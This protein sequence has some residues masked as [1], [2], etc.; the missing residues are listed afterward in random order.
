MCVCVCMCVHYMCVNIINNI[1]IDIFYIS[2]FELSQNKIYMFNR[3][4]CTRY[5]YIFCESPRSRYFDIS[6]VSCMCKKTH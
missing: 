6:W 2:H 3:D 1:F 4:S 5:L